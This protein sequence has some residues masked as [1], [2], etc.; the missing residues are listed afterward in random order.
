KA[1]LE[2]IRA[3][4]DAD[5]C[6]MVIPG[7]PGP[8]ESYQMYRVTRGTTPSRSA[9]PE[10]GGEAAA[11]FLSPSLEYAVVYRKSGSSQTRLFELKTKVFTEAPSNNADKLAGMLDAQRYLS[12]PV[13]YRHQPVGRMYIVNGPSHIDSRGMEFMLQL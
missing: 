12:V 4:Y 1:I 6:L 10:I 7:K 11:Q 2:S 3:F 8:A 9:P 13:Y 5:A